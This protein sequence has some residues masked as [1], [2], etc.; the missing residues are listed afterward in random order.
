MW[1][2]KDDVDKHVNNFAVSREDIMR[3]RGSFH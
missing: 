3:G 1:D 2:N